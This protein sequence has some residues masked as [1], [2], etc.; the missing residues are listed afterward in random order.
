MKDKLLQGTAP[1]TD[2][3][4]RNGHVTKHVQ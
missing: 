2:K 1:I 3:A 4:T